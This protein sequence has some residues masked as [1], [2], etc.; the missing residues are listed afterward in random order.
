MFKHLL[1]LLLVSVSSS[2][3][4][5]SC[6]AK[7]EECK[8]PVTNPKH[9]EDRHCTCFTCRTGTSEQ[10][11]LCTNDENEAGK[12]QARVEASEGTF[13]QHGKPLKQIGGEHYRCCGNRECSIRDCAGHVSSF[14]QNGLFNY[15]KPGFRMCRQG[16]YK[17]IECD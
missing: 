13:A 16:S 15:R 7:A 6:T 1:L 4:Q 17:L 5:Q 2:A 3:L 10:K 9:Y 8:D 11:V 12:L 14:L